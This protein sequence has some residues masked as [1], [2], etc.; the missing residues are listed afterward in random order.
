MRTFNGLFLL[1]FGSALWLTAG[2]LLT[3]GTLQ[4]PMRQPGMAF[5]L[6]G[7]RLLLV[8]AG[9][10]LAGTTLLLAALRVARGGDLRPDA[11]TPAE[12]AC[13]MAAIGCLALGL[14]TAPRG[15]V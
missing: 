4:V 8:A 9:P 5:T 7:L 6:N 11:I 15:P 13:F 2:W 10:A 1:V 14:L 3:Q 12:T